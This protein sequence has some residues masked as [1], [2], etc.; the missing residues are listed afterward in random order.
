[1]KNYL[2]DK[3]IL[4][5]ELLKAIDELL[6]NSTDIVFGGSIA[7]NA[8]GVIKR[9]IK[10]I[11]LM[12]LK[13]FPLNHYGLINYIQKNESKEASETTT[14]V[15][16]V[17]IIRVPAKVKNINVCIFKVENISFSEFI[18][19]GRKIKIQNIN[20]AILAK[21]AYSEKPFKS[22]VKH[23]RDIKEIDSK[24]RDIFNFKII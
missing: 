23:K 21:R 2:E 15:N 18:F 10:D 5:S 11:D 20:E 22:C 9:P 6:L 19:L 24:I 13:R 7:L 1:M 14:D 12:T 4:S 3:E 16:G 17:D 8:V